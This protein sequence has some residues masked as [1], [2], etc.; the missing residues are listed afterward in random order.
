MSL[1]ERGPS[2]Q[3]SSV[4]EDHL[5]R[6]APTTM[7]VGVG[8]S[9]IVETEAT[10][11]CGG[12]WKAPERSPSEAVGVLGALEAVRLVMARSV[13]TRHACRPAIE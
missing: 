11:T 13:E 1:D 12:C 6:A 3:S 4:W 8:L 2:R 9:K 7:R 5:G 10:T